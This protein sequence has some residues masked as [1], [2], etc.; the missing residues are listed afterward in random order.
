[1]TLLIIFLILAVGVSFLC[2]VMEAVLLSLTPG[3]IAARQ[4]S[5]P[6]L[7]NRLASLKQD[8]DQP[9]AAIL[10]LNT[11]AHTVGATGVGAQAAVVFADISVGVI[12]AVLTLLILVFSEI[13]PKTLGAQ[14][15][16][17]LAGPVVGLV[18]A[19]MFLMY[20]L[21]WL[22]RQLVRLISGGKDRASVSRA[23]LVALAEVG[24]TEG[25][26]ESGEA[27]LLKRVMGFREIRVEDVMTPRPVMHTLSAD[28]TVGEVFE[29][30][31]DL[32]FSRIPIYTGDPD[33]IV[34]HVLKIDI[35]RD[36]ADDRHERQL[37]DLRRDL[38]SVPET[39]PLSR[40][41]DLLIQRQDHLALVV[42]EYGTV[43]GLVTIEDAIETL[44]GM[45]IV[46]ETDEVPD[47]RK[48]ARQVREERSRR[49]GYPQPTGDE[50]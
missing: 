50:R 47:M 19:T 34:G 49:L 1:M 39:L 24:R 14:Y 41:L 44:I 35:L 42:N 46:D 38:L 27:R 3:F 28:L 10:S 20:P 37:K 6:A 7:G 22:S 29:N 12:S 9:L 36:V 40:V 2:S 43:M 15:W 17:E 25:V 23:E 31:S 8:I 21:V 11:I 33:E 16:R 45:E 13:I 32:R 5:R 26:L 4:K 48:L 30:P 18:R